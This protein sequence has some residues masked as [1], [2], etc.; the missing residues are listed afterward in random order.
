MGQV[1]RQLLAWFALLGIGVGTS[2][3]ESAGKHE[4]A[5]IVH[6]DY[7]KKDWSTFFQFEKELENAI[8]AAAVG[9]YDG[10]ELAV[11][12]SDG[13][14]YIYGPDADKLFAFVRPRLLAA[15]F[16]KNVIVTL[17]YGAVSDPSVRETK[18]ELRR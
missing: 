10:N 5:V 4:E 18:I 17:R 7:G 12:G 8:S 1:I 6:F 13:S 11:D 2:K 3:V 16:L 14:M 9:E 15:T